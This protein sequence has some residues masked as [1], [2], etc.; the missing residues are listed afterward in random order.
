MEQRSGKWQ[1][2]ASTNLVISARCTVAQ[3]IT[4]VFKKYVVE[5]PIPPI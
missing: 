5:I 1:G 2:I 4:C 3:T